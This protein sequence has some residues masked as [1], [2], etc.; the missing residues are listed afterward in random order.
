MCRHSLLQNLEMGRNDGN[1]IKIGLR[2]IF[3]NFPTLFLMFLDN[4]YYFKYLDFYRISIQ[5]AAAPYEL[6]AK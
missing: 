1:I 6:V 2:I 5:G 4:H 3:L